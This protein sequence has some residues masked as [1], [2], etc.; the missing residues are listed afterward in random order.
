MLQ[1]FTTNSDG[2]LA[3][4]KPHDQS[5]WLNV[6]RPTIAEINQ[7]VR[8]FNFPKDYL[9][10]V[11][12]DAEISRTE[13]LTHASADQATLIVMQ[14]PKLTTSDLGYLEYQVYPFALIL[15]PKAVL[16]VSNYPASFIQDFIMDPTSSRLSLADHE[17]FVLTIMWYIS[18][19]Y[20][21]ALKAINHK[22]TILERRLTRATRNEEI[23]RIMAYQKSLIRFK[24]ALTQN[25]PI[26]AA[27][28]HS[29]THFNGSQHKALTTDIIVENQQ[30]A[31]MT[32]TTNQILQQYSQLVSSVISNNL[33]D[34]MKVLT[35][36]TLILT[37]PTIIGGIYGMN[38]RLPGAS[39]VHAF[40]WIMLGTIILCIISIEYLRNHD[41]F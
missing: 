28:E 18:H 9:T 36:L 10:A 1:Y 2:R 15:T 33:N 17:N 7:L 29:A 39:V 40:S 3:I 24:A 25:A 32:N 35:S 14:F 22:T 13:Q 37:I 27:V 31:D 12:D 26:L 19:A 20:V 38:V 5:Y 41:Y 30:A 6:E 11:L 34:V 21:T 16:T 23:F 4:G 8:E